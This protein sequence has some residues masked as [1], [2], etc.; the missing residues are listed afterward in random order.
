MKSLKKMM[1][2]QNAVILGVLI[3]AI[4]FSDRLKPL[5]NNLLGKLVLLLAI[6]YLS[7]QHIVFGLLG[8]LLYISL[9]NTLIEGAEGDEEP[10]ADTDVVVDDEENKD[11]FKEGGDGDDDAADEEEEGSK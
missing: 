5:A 3:L 4:L 8:A 9:N 11:G 10:T 1:K 6:C 7:N 2:N